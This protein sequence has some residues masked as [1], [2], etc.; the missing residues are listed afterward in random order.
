MKTNTKTNLLVIVVY[1]PFL[2]TNFYNIELF[3]FFLI[4]ENLMNV[5]PL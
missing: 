4:L 1:W 3:S 5:F 2:W